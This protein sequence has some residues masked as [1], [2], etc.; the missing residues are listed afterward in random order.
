MYQQWQARI[1]YHHW[2]KQAAAGGKC[3]DMVAFHRLCATKGGEPD[4]L[5]KEIPTIFTVQLSDEVISSHFGFGV[6]NRPNSVKQ[7]LTS[8][9]RSSWLLPL[10]CS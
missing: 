2:K 5:E 1:A 10:C 3:T 7:L 8:Q 4:G 9:M 6:L